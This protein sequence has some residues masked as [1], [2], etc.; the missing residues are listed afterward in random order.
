MKLNLTEAKLL[1]SNS[2]SIDYEEILKNLNS[3]K[4]ISNQDCLGGEY[5]CLKTHLNNIGD[6]IYFFNAL[7]S[8][9]LKNE[10]RSSI[11]SYYK[12]FLANSTNKES[13]FLF[14][15]KVSFSTN[16]SNLTISYKPSDL[17]LTLCFA[18]WTLWK[19]NI[20]IVESGGSIDKIFASR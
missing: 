12:L 6:V 15:D 16:T 7:L 10:V 9:E 4:E 5:S 8:F 17:L 1:E 20:N 3:N 13:P 19:V 2:F 14:Y 11:N 18:V